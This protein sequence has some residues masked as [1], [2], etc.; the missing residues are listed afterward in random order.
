MLQDVIGAMGWLQKSRAYYRY[1][2]FRV[3]PKGYFNSTQ[4]MA[5]I[6]VQIIQDVERYQNERLSK[7]STEKDNYRFTL[8]WEDGVWKITN[9]AD[10]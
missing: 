4:N 2:T 3:E 5:E 10:L 8:V 1:G 7:S 9:R 6:E